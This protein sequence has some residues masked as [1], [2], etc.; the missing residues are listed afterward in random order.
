LLLPLQQNP[1]P[2][3]VLQHLSHIQQQSQRH[4]AGVQNPQPLIGDLIHTS[5]QAGAQTPTEAPA[6][7][8]NTLQPSRLDSAL[9][10]PIHAPLGPKMITEFCGMFELRDEICATLKEEQFK[11]TKGFQYITLTDLK[12]VDFRKDDIASFRNAIQEW[13]I[14][15]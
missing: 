12:E 5:M 3:A 11:D 15:E 9:I 14:A 10:I 13:L 8:P 1:L 6:V 4:K 2:V 7:V